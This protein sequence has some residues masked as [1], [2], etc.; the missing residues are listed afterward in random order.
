LLPGNL[1][2]QFGNAGSQDADVVTLTDALT[3]RLRNHD[4][5][6]RAND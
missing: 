2:A 6:R 1:I 3:G 4:I 5:A